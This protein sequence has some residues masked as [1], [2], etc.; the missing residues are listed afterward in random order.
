MN[1]VFFRDAPFNI[2]K[3]IV[4]SFWI[5]T[6]YFWLNVFLYVKLIARWYF[7]AL[8]SAIFFSFARYIFSVVYF[9]CFHFFHSFLLNWRAIKFLNL[10]RIHWNGCLANINGWLTR[11]FC[12][13][14]CNLN[15]K[16]QTNT[17]TVPSS[18]VASLS[19]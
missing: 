16:T 19:G 5:Y 11:C 10:F 13:S 4:L 18:F 1:F 3:T 15:T 17:F 12:R 9:Y 14:V 7:F 2:W 8:L 6:F